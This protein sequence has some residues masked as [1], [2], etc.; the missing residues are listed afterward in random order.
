MTHERTR[1]TGLKIKIRWI[2][3]RSGLGSEYFNSELK[4]SFMAVLEE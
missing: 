2:V 3:A 4:Y 1:R